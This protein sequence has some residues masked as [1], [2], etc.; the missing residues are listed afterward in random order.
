MT[1]TWRNGGGVSAGENQRNVIIK[2]SVVYQRKQR[3]EISSG[4]SAA[5]HVAKHHGI[6]GVENIS[7]IMAWRKING[8][9]SI[10][11]KAYKHI[12]SMAW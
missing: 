4:V 5:W 10:W 8:E 6:S 11:H 1:A 3:S 7:E 2:R 9:T 12:S